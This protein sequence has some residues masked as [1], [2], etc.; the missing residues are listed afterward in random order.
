MIELA[1]HIEVL[2]LE[3]DCVIIPNLGGFV[4][5]YVSSTCV[6]E[7]NVFLPPTRVIGFNSQLKMNDG[8]IVQSYMTVYGTNFSDATRMVEQQV[9]NLIAVLHEDGKVE[10][11]NVGELHYTIDNKYNFIPYD[12]KVTTSYLY[13]LDI[14]V[15]QKLSAIKEEKIKREISFSAPVLPERPTI[16][17]YSGYLAKAAAVAAIILLSFFIST[18]IQNTEVEKLNYAKLLPGELFEKV[19]KQ[20]LAFH[21]IIVKQTPIN[22]TISI[23]K[24]DTATEKAIIPEVAVKPITATNIK[25]NATTI[26]SSISKPYYIIIASLGT[27]KD[28]KNMAAQLNANG[29]P[30][31]K[32]I[33]GEGK[34]R[35]SINSYET[36]S[37]AYQ[38]LSDIRQNEN[39]KNAWVLKQ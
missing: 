1:Q 10:I 27:E 15:M 3:N 34:M 25:V 36:E 11:P 9:K 24:K 2:L 18:P 13:G 30:K 26:V 8:L 22:N 29:F 4:T 21:P 14:F 37:K 6:K 35:V 12:N 28:A 5:H 39:Y 31:A 19:E 33:I 20:S 38:A 17:L 23:T 16:K 7:E 32:A